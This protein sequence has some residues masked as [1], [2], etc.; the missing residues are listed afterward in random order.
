[1]ICMLQ[2][3]IAAWLLYKRTAM[4][5]Y[6]SDPDVWMLYCAARLA[7]LDAAAGGLESF[8]SVARLLYADD[9]SRSL[10]PIAAAERYTASAHLVAA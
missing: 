2:T 7:E 8:Q 1:M 6:L 4:R 9:A 3:A 5:P 10:G